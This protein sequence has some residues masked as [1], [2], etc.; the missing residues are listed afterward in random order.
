MTFI[1]VLAI[2][3]ASVLLVWHIPSTESQTNA[4]A[5]TTSLSGE[6][7]KMWQTRRVVRHLWHVNARLEYRLDLHTCDPQPDCQSGVKLAW[8]ML[9]DQ[10]SGWPTP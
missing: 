6:R 9:G 1:A 8:Q 2:F 10:W 5:A 7:L 4:A 3:I